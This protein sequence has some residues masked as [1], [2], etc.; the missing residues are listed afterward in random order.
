[1]KERLYIT[2]YPDNIYKTLWLNNSKY[3]IELLNLVNLSDRD[4][5]TRRE[6]ARKG[7]I[8]SGKARLEKAFIEQYLIYYLELTHAKDQALN[9][10]TEYNGRYKSKID[11]NDLDSINKY[12]PL[13]LLNKLRALYNRVYREQ[14]KLKKIIDKYKDK[15]NNG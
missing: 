3:G 11:V 13:K 10:I 8:A 12:L 6:I 14:N 9:I 2:D 4:Q 7:G 5:D 1:M 15:Y